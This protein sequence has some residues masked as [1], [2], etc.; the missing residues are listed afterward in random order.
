MSVIIGTYI[1]Y[2]LGFGSSKIFLF[3]IQYTSIIVIFYVQTSFMIIIN[4]SVHPILSSIIIISHIR[5]ASIIIIFDIHLDIFHNG[6]WIV[7]GLNTI[8]ENSIPPS[9]CRCATPSHNRTMIFSSS[10]WITFVDKR[11]GGKVILRCWSGTLRCAIGFL[12][13][14]TLGRIGILRYRPFASVIIF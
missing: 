3:N 8:H 9:R 14:W 2:W 5:Y 6:V 13:N 1:N 11:R 12:I 4:V 10:L 7:L